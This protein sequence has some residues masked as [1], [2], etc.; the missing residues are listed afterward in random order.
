MK[1]SKKNPVSTIKKYLIYFLPIVL[2]FS[3]YPIISLGSNSSMNFELSLPLIWLLIFSLISLPTVFNF[4][5][6]IKINIFSLSLIFPLYASI[7]VIWSPNFPRAILT[8]G[9][10]WCLWISVLSL[11]NF[12]HF[13]LKN[14]TIFQNRLVQIIFLSAAIVCLFCWIQCLLDIFGVSRQNTLLC[15]GCTFRSFGFPHPNGFAIEP[16]FMGNL[17]LAPIFLSL[18]L[19]IKSKNN[20]QKIFLVLASGFF[21]GTLFLTFSRG[22]IY[23]FVV[24]IIILL[25]AQII[26]TKQFGA[27]KI[28]PLIFCSFLLTLS[29]QGLFAEFSQTNDTFLSG[30]SKSIN[31]LSL[32]IINIPYSITKPESNV[33]EDVKT[34]SSFDGYVEE[35]TDIRLNLSSVALKAWTQSSAIF[36]FGSGLGS[37]GITMSSISPELGWEKEITQNEFFEIALELGLVGLIIVSIVIIYSLKII[38]HNNHYPLFL[39]S[40]C[41]FGLSYLFFSGFPNALHIFLLPPLLFFATKDE[42]VINKI[43][44]NHC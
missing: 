19:L 1:N 31:Q 30:V 18:Y 7:S 17:L 8:V 33:L 6:K 26:Q 25:I 10:I 24:G 40:I 37:S 35:S 41:A 2:F 11:W 4:F 15:L 43:T 28:L 38:I 27:L 14:K 23:A 22:A 21:I 5:K 44:Q 34:D 36:F 29:C 42:S 16:Q 13:E 39:G 3:Y 20:H 32:G 9:I 12:F